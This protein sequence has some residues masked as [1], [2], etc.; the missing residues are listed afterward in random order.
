MF[1]FPRHDFPPDL[2]V[3][4]GRDVFNDEQ[5]DNGTMT[6][7]D[8]ETGPAP[9]EELRRFYKPPDVKP[10]READAKTGNLKDPQKIAAKMESARAKHEAR[11]KEAVQG[12]WREFVDAAPLS[13]MVGRVLAI[14]YYRD[15]RE[16]FLDCVDPRQPGDGEA[17]LLQTFWDYAR[18]CKVRDVS[19][20]GHS[21]QRFDLPFLCQRSWLHGVEIPDF[22]CDWR[23]YIHSMFVDLFDCWTFHGRKTE[24]K[25]LPARS[26][27]PLA[28]FFGAGRKPDNCSGATFHRLFLSADAD[29]HRAALDYLRND[30]EMTWGVAAAMNLVNYTIR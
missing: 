9:E 6:V 4:A 15:D 17:A 3:A 23:G 24:S 20:C 26:L 14:G 30:L 21:I 8:I 18:F 28:V 5:V 22:V 11:E 27:N 13:A 29:D 25:P 1:E 19:L 10:F 16:P 12:R 7:F 2:P